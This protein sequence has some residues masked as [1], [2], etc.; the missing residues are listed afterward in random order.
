MTTQ[1]D[2]L[3]ALEKFL[4][5]HAH[6]IASGVE[7]RI[8]YF[9]DRQAEFEAE[10]IVEKEAG[11]TAGAET[12]ANFRKLMSESADQF[13]RVLEEWNRLVEEAPEDEDDDQEV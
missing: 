3:E 2:R 13:R 12:N 5:D 8:K 6:E 9:E 11:N 10:R 1:T 7:M 4:R